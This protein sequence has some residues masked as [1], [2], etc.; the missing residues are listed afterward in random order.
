MLLALNKAF[1]YL[2]CQPRIFRKVSP[3]VTES[4]CTQKMIHRRINTVGGRNTC[5]RANTPARSKQR[6]DSHQPHAPRR[7]R[8]GDAQ[9]AGFCTPGCRA[10]LG[11]RF[12]QEFQSHGGWEVE[13]AAAAGV[14]AGRG[15]A[16]QRAGRAGPG[17]RGPGG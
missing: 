10:G 16:P 11:S 5:T 7:Q 17:A 12:H 6:H 9:P 14:E 1:L 4:V 13:E 3:S 2:N 8:A 15:G